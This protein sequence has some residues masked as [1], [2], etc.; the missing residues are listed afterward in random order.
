MFNVEVMGFFMGVYI[1][2]CWEGTWEPG[3]GIIREKIEVEWMKE[4]KR[5]LGIVFFNQFHFTAPNQETPFFCLVDKEIKEK[6]SLAKLNWFGKIN[7]FEIVNQF[8]IF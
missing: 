4:K 8:E 2:L 6:K 7:W 5:H 1:G 3:W